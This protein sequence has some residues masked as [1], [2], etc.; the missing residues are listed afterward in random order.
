[1]P[2]VSVQDQ[3]SSALRFAFSRVPGVVDRVLCSNFFVCRKLSQ[4]KVDAEGQD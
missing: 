4:A 2:S 3:A 1:M